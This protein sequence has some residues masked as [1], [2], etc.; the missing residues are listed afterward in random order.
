MMRKPGDGVVAA[1]PDWD[2]SA[3]PEY[4]PNELSPPEWTGRITEAWGKTLAGVFETASLLL[5]A[6]SALAHGEFQAMVESDLPF[7]PRTARRLMAIGRDKRLTERTHTSVLPPSWMTLYE[8]TRLDDA[9]FDAA[10]ADGTIRP[11][12]GQK[13]IRARLRQLKQADDE[14]RVMSVTPVVGT[15]RTIMVDPP[16]DYEWLSLAGR[17]A[18]GYATM[19]HAE[20]LDLP[21]PSWADDACQMYLWT[22]NNFMTRAVDL[23]QMWGFQHKTVITWVKPRWGLGS[24]FRNSTEHMLFGTRGDTTTRVDNIATHF[25]APVGEHSEK[26]GRAYAIAEA[27]SY[28]PRLEVFHRGDRVGWDRAYE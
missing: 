19:S 4:R 7:G 23:M 12:M 10:I 1:L 13:D 14:E 16:W 27:A 8:L 9:D 18:P 28:P 22:T 3:L 17:A 26:P 15:Y 2:P 5:E 20:L 25:E 24:Y 11:D 21:V 6:K